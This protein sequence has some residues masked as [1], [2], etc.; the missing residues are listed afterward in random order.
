MENKYKILFEKEKKKNSFLLVV[1]AILI[2]S[3]LLLTIKCSYIKKESEDM[4]YLNNK[5]IDTTNDLKNL[6]NIDFEDINKINCYSG[7]AERRFTYE[8]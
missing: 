1:I 7:D 5:L 6:L 2:I 3:F 8:Q 4:C